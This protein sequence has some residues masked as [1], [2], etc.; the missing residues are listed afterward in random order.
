MSQAQMVS[1]LMRLAEFMRISDEAA[2]KSAFQLLY[3]CDAVYNLSC[4][5]FFVIICCVSLKAV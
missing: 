5:G 1:G 3:E 4:L 2:R